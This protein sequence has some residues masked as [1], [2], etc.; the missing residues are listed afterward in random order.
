M[1]RPPLVV[2]AALAAVGLVAACGAA[3]KAPIAQSSQRVTSNVR[4]EDYVGSKVCVGCHRSEYEAFVASPMHR[5]TRA[6][7]EAEVHAPFAGETFALNGDQ[8]R[9]HQRDGARW[10]DLLSRDGSAKTYRLTKVIGGRYREDFVGIEQGRAAEEQILPV[11][12]LIFDSSYRYKG[13]SVLVTE[14]NRL[15]AGQVWRQSCIFCHN[16]PAQLFTLFDELH[17]PSFPSYQGSTSD[18]APGDRRFR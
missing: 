10:L 14:R 4:S 3:P 18:D 13:Y 2:F 11:S 12:Y 7:P 16:T 1:T 5:M 15:E 8:A 6:L 17:G 9:M